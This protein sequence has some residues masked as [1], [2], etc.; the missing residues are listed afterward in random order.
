[1]LM[2]SDIETETLETPRSPDE[3]EF[4]RFQINSERT[5]SSTGANTQEEDIDKEEFNDKSNLK[6]K[7][8]I[9]ENI[10]N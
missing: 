8:T 1:M 6:Q 9:S 4:C 5:A 7:L 3:T 10:K 2:S